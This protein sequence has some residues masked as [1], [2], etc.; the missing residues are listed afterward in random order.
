MP[1]SR[2]FTQDGFGRRITFYVGQEASGSASLPL[3]LFIL[4]SGAY[5]NLLVRDG[6][7]LFAHRD[8]HEVLRGRAR[9]LFVEKVGVSFGA[10]VARTGTAMGSTE[11]FRQEHTF[12]RWLEA[13]SASLRA[14]RTLTGIDL[15]R[16]L[17]VG[18]SEGA[19]MAAAVAAR[20][21][22]VTDVA[23]LAG[24]GPTQ[25][26]DFVAEARI[27][28]LLSEGPTP[29]AQM[30]ALRRR[31]SDIRQHAAD[32]NRMWLGH[33]YT[34]W[35]SFMAGA[36]FGELERGRSRVF[37]AQGSLD[38]IHPQYAVDLVEATLMAEGRDVTALVVD[39]ANHDFQFKDQTKNGRD[40]W[41]EILQT[42]V[43]WFFA[44]PMHQVP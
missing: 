3:A 32:P 23:C 42:V 35:S 13:L 7:V 10:Q 6:K 41:R 26:F 14:A 39:G 18:H 25:L 5:S 20:N 2:Y 11:E 19:L 24:G 28:R 9:L 15:R 31:W 34:Y 12:G 27:G 33:P 21:D 40:G 38:G 44:P 29:V 37:V 16:T 43:S 30:Q 17:V 4:G 36:M 22:F 1:L 8:F